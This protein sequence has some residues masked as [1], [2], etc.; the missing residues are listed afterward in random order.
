[1]W[2]FNFFGACSQT[3]LIPTVLTA[4]LGGANIALALEP[5]NLVPQD[6]EPQC[7]I[8]VLA[9]FSGA[10]SVYGI[11]PQRGI[12]LA[13]HDISHPTLSV[14][15]EDHKGEA[16]GAV[17]AVKA[18]LGREPNIHALVVVGASPALAVAPIITARGIPLLAVA[19]DDRL[20]AVRH[21]DSS[22]A[23]IIRVWPSG[24]EE[25][26]V[27][28]NAM[29]V[30][31]AKNALVIHDHD[32]YSRAVADGIA[33]PGMNVERIEAPPG[34]IDI[35]ALVQRSLKKVGADAAVGLCVR[36]G[37]VGAVALQLRE[38]GFTGQI[39]GCVTADNEQEWKVARGALSGAVYGSVDVRADF[40]TRY[41]NRYGET[42]FI[43]GAAA[44][45]DI[46]L[47][48]DAACRRREPR[49]N[50]VNTL[51]E[52]CDDVTERG[53]IASARWNC[54][55]KKG[56]IALTPMLALGEVYSHAADDTNPQSNHEL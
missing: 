56:V 46:T 3:V 34:S 43:G 18:L 30:R 33:S 22:P 41:K 27:L 39:F 7:H 1:M 28:A 14:T 38:L 40:K 50:I 47:M 36:A 44:L 6:L 17:S 42:S 15:Y 48:L 54:E 25:G 2:N 45:Y 26:N 32:D 5:Q 51:R 52:A 10:A 35:R 31:G 12:A 29:L 37:R 16:A 9:P 8:G 55:A 21:G 4:F 49:A 24:A 11:A 53:V 20:G 19:S 23:L 13:L